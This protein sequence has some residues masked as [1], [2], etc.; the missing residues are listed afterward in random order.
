MAFYPCD[1]DGH[2]NPKKNYLFYWAL[3]SGLNFTRWRQRLCLA[4]AGEIQEDLSEYKVGP[5]D[6]ALSSGGMLANCFSCGN[7]IAE[8]GRQLFLTCY[9]SNDEREDYWARIHDDCTLPKPWLTTQLDL[10]LPPP[11]N[12]SI[13]PEIVNPPRSRDRARMGPVPR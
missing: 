11:Q 13:S 12:V 10:P 5:L 1:F 9:P 2:F 7:P 3:G 8:G 4:H 6:A